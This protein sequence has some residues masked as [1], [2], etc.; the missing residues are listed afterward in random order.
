MYTQNDDISVAHK[1]N[2]KHNRLKH[3]L[4]QENRFNVKVFKTYIEVMSVCIVYLHVLEI[5]IRDVSRML[6]GCEA[7]DLIEALTRS[8]K[9]NA[10]VSVS[11]KYTFRSAMTLPSWRFDGTTDGFMSSNP[12]LFS[13]PFCTYVENNKHALYE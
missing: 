6:P 11:S 8:C 7:S 9:S 10:E 2:T 3:F 13:K 12:A 5:I 4:R 1:I